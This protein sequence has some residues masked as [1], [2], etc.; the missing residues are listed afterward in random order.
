MADVDIPRWQWWMAPARVI[1]RI[2]PGLLA[3]AAS[4]A[5]VIARLPRVTGAVVIPVVVIGLAATF[6]ALHAFSPGVERALP[7]NWLRLNMEDL[8]TEIPAFLIAAIIIGS[9]SPA[10]AVLFVLSF[11]AFDLVA[12]TRDPHELPMSADRPFALVGR[13]VAYWLLWLLAVEIPV[14]GRTLARSGRGLASSKF[15]AAA[16]S[17]LV[18]AVFTL[19]WAHGSAVLFR[20]VYL[21]SDIGGPFAQGFVFLQN[22]GHVFALIAGV[23]AV[24]V[25]LVRGPSELLRRVRPSRAAHGD[26]RPQGQGLPGALVSGARQLIGAGLLTI[27]LGGLITRPVDAVVVFAALAGSRP[28]ARVLAQR[29]PIGSITVRLPELVRLATAFALAF[30]V[31]YVLVLAPALHAV[32]EFFSVIVVFAIG[33]FVIEL[34][35][36]TGTPGAAREQSIALRT[37]VAAVALLGLAAFGALAPAPAFADNVGNLPDLWAALILAALGGLGIPIVVWL[38]KRPE[39]EI[40]FTFGE[41]QRVSDE[42]DL[43]MTFGDAKRVPGNPPKAPK[44]RLGFKLGPARRVPSPPKPK[45]DAPRPPSRPGPEE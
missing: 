37:G 24:L 7:L 12:A 36:A 32:S 40:D 35:T 29:S 41:P 34:M 13:L 6:A 10:A 3:A 26:A 9:L 14:L 31:S 42:P 30:L 25:A 2:R 20:P 22:E 4:D 19:F 23:S 28:L 8:Y 16:V 43:E 39:P 5:S 1:G 38:A 44:P 45:G 33:L 11:G 18:A 15:V 17:G 27:C 21:W